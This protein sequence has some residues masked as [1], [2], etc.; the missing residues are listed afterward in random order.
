MLGKK[1][2]CGTD[3]SRP[4]EKAIAFA[5]ALAKETGMAVTFVNVN[6]VDLAMAQPTRHF[7]DRQ[8]IAVIDEQTGREMQAA[9]A[10]AEEAGVTDVE[11]VVVAARNPA[12]AIVSYA[13]EHG[14]DH[15]VV[16]H[17]GR[18][19]IGR[20][21]LGSVARDVVSYAAECPVTVVPG[22]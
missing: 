19:A 4:A 12:K 6:L 13:A 5:V 8:E 14:C 16:G 17:G 21:V 3:G 18:G 1:L 9:R 22:G 2:L 15:I 11:Y 20:W 10:L 7:W